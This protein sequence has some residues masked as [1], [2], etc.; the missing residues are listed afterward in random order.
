MGEKVK[1]KKKERKRIGSNERE[2]QKCNG[3]RMIERP[4]RGQGGGDSL[5]LFY[6]TV[7]IMCQKVM[8]ENIELRY[9]HAYTQTNS[10]TQK[11]HPTSTDLL[12]FE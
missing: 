10:L 3:E 1:K 2:K 12:G 5:K 4:P 11:T 7:L 8:V 9:A 6:N